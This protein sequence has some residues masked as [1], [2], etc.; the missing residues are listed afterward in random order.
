M[1]ETQQ[2]PGPELIPNPQGNYHFLKG[3]APFSFGC[4]ADEGYEIERV[5]FHP[6]PKDM[7]DGFN[8]IKAYM[9]KIGRPITALCGIELRM[10]EALPF[11]AFIQFNQGYEKRLEEWGLLLDGTNPLARTNVVYEYDPLKEASVYGFS[12]TVPAESKRKTFVLSG[13]PEITD[14]LEMVR[15]GET[16]PRRS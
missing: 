7:D 1:S 11:P 10:P 13:M 2:A 16:S 4:L 5:T 15:A 9:E 12:Y 3:I 14:K 6:L 8:R